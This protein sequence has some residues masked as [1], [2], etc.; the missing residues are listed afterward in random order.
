LVT[1]R[2]HKEQGSLLHCEFKTVYKLSAEEAHKLEKDPGQWGDQFAS[3]I[4]VNKG[5]L[6]TTVAGWGF[7]FLDSNGKPTDSHIVSVKAETDSPTLPY[8]LDGESSASW[9]MPVASLARHIDA[10]E[11]S[12]AFHGLMAFVRTGDDRMIY[13]TKPVPIEP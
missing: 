11:Q 5:R 1:Y 12:S 6:A 10:H 9:E 7:A 3:V 2:I 4:A 13:A 8:R